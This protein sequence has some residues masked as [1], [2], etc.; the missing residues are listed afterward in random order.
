MTTV[1]VV[2]GA[3]YIG[4]H[5]VAALAEGGYGVVTL[6]NLSRGH[7]E[8]VLA[9]EFVPGDFGDAATLDRLFGDPARDPRVPDLVVQPEHGVI[10]TTY[11]GTIAEHGG[12]TLDDRNV[13]LLVVPGGKARGPRTKLQPVT[14][15]Q[16]APTI[17]AYLG[18]SP[19]ALQAVRQEHTTA[20]QPAGS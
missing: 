11:T 13:A 19:N 16:I 1:L 9:G 3:G 18:L 12:G 7:R 5:M 15:S 10:Y 17:L 20:L 8:H 4:S 6:D 14:T 2:G